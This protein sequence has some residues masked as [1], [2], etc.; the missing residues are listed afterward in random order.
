MI[1]LYSPKHETF[2]TSTVTTGIIACNI[3]AIIKSNR[4]KCDRFT[5]TPNRLGFEAIT[6]GTKS[7][8][9]L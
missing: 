2:I 9:I 5:V 1:M 3:S 8:C 4:M 7:I 6:I